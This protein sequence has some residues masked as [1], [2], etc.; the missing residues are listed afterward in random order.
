MAHVQDLSWSLGK[1]FS[2]SGVNPFRN[3][4][5]MTVSDNV[6]SKPLV[7]FLSEGSGVC[8]ALRCFFLFVDK[9]LSKVDRPDGG[10]GSGQSTAALMSRIKVVGPD[11]AG[12]GF[13]WFHGSISRDETNRRLTDQPDGTF[14]IRESTNYPGDYTL[15]IAFRGNVEH[16]RIFNENLMLTCDHEGFFQSLQLLVAHYVKDADGLCHK[17]VRPLPLSDFQKYH[18]VVGPLDDNVHSAIGDSP[19]VIDKD[20]LQLHEVIGHGEFGDVVAG[21]YRGQKV[22]IKVMKRGNH[23]I[24]S[25]LQEASMMM[26]V[27]GAKMFEKKR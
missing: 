21:E 16:Y 22:A 4:D 19:W 3:D 25:L 27:C 2:V 26:Y 9:I 14:L 5:V 1:P 6:A 7:Y 15:C 18:S 17:L 23:V 11:P 13:T 10:S 8:I 20:D 12:F 24:E